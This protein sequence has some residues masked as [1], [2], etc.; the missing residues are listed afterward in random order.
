MTMNRSIFIAILV[1]VFSSGFFAQDG[2]KAA[3]SHQGAVQEYEILDRPRAPYTNA[4]R[5]NGV[6]GIVSLRVQLLATGRIGRVTPVTS[7]PFGLT[8]QAIR[9]ARSIRFRPRMVNGKPVDIIITVDYRFTLY[10]ENSDSDITTK[11]AITNMPP[12]D[13]RRSEI[14]PEAEGRIAVEVF[15]GADGRVSVFRYVSPLSDEQ[16][17]KIDEAVANIEFKPAIHKSGKPMS[18]T[19]VVDYE[20]D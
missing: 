11:V 1:F 18:V 15:F 17:R 13:I 5:Q 2:G 8:E 4:A 9:S 14:I 10:Y 16:K 20:V 6:E 3:A 12:P 7:L 19:K